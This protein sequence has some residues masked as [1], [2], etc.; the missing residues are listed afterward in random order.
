[1]TT[2]LE[3]ATSALRAGDTVAKAIVASLEPYR[4]N[5]S[6]YYVENGFRLVVSR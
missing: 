4:R 6:G 1:M 3:A 5:D 2:A